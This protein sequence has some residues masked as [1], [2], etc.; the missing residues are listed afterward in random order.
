MEDNFLWHKVSSE[1]QEKIKKEA[2]EIMDSFSK[3]LEKAEAEMPEEHIVRRAQQSRKEG[4]GKIDRDFRKLFF[5]NAP[6][7]SGDYIKAERG[8]WK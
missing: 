3:A 7:K 5:E 8:K 4:R 1:E 2:K 6:S